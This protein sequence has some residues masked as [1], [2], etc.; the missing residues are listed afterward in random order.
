MADA[1]HSLSENLI[2]SRFTPIACHG[3]VAQL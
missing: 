3:K 1:L 2:F